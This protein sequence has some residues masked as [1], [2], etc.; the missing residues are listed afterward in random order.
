MSFSIRNRN[1]FDA[2]RQI[3]QSV[4]E[5]STIPNAFSFMAIP[6]HIPRTNVNTKYI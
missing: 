4:R 6:Y 2:A 1:G 3:F 5:C